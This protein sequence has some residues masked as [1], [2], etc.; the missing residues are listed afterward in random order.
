MLAVPALSMLQ[1]FLQSSV[2]STFEPSTRL[3]TIQVVPEKNVFPRILHYVWPN[4][5]FSFG[6][7]DP[8]GIEQRRTLALVEIIRDSNPEWEVKIW[9]DDDCYSLMKKHFP[10]FYPYWTALTPR[11]KMWDAVRPAILH[12]HGGIY[13][14]HDIDCDEGVHFTNWLSPQT[15]LLLREPSIGKRRKLGNHF[16]GSSPGHSIWKLYMDNIVK[17][18]PWNYPV[19][20]HTGPEQLYATFQEYIIGITL[21]QRS[22]LRLLGLHELDM[23]GECETAAA[24][25]GYCAQ[26]RCSHMHTV[27]PA[28][29]A[30]EDD[31]YEKQVNEFRQGLARISYATSA[32]ACK[33]LERSI[34][35]TS[36]LDSKQDNVPVLFVNIPETGGATIE[37]L[38]KSVEPCHASA[39]ELRA[40]D[41]GQY[42]G[43]LT[44]AALRNPIER[45]VLMYKYA[46]TKGNESKEDPEKFDW[47]LG[48]DFA[49]F[50]EA[51]PAR[52]ELNFAPQKHF[53]T[54][55]DSSSL[56][57][58][59][60]ICTE[61]LGAGWRTLQT[62]VPGLMK[63]KS[64][65]SES[66]DLSQVEEKT[67][68]CLR[69]IY[70]DDFLLWEEYCGSTIKE[71]E[72]SSQSSKEM[73]AVTKLAN[74]TDDQ[75][76]SLL[77]CGDEG[78]PCAYFYPALF[79][80][81]PS[82]LGYMQNVTAKRQ[83]YG[84]PYRTFHANWVRFTH[85]QQ[86]YTYIHTRKA[87]GTTMKFVGEALT[88]NGYAHARNNR[89]GTTLKFSGQA[90][91]S[92]GTRFTADTQFTNRVKRRYEA[93]G[94]TQF[95][96]ETKNMVNS[97]TLFTFVRDPLSR[98][99]SAMGQVASKKK[100]QV[101]LQERG[102]FTG[103]AVND[104]KCVLERMKNGDPVNEH[105][106]QASIEMYQMS[107]S[108]H[109]VRVAVMSLKHLNSFNKAVLKMN[110]IRANTA[111]SRSRKKQAYSTNLL[112]H[113]MIRDICI[114]YEMDVIMMRSL[115]LAVP[116]CDEFVTDRRRPPR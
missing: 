40:C 37:R 34:N 56:L 101:S 46:H 17:D 96:D 15:S 45:A 47:A 11:L 43:S 79:Y 102:C 64:S 69:E 98:F 107:F 90:L 44:F 86:D 76:K 67:E 97:T 10:E 77:D 95:I 28:E 12:V 38:L 114:V 22:Q 13:L 89:G 20:R 59:E 49:A 41:A 83:L 71:Q 84:S 106:M 74:G 111:D 52:R 112:D 60:I 61:D 104:M 82:G 115:G 62:F 2:L 87:G 100:Q 30:G 31:N 9:T 78:S 94:E 1:W 54:L 27:S 93:I 7:E 39:A 48:M 4:K 5:N 24:Y 53:L 42:D 16:M 65:P 6:D 68:Q 109:H 51:L 57:V 92:N 35:A 110:P 3:S 63:F 55:P 66:F 108:L 75:D 18:I 73:T 116:G 19:D 88:S 72:R 103:I 8:Q 81:S 33:H 105:F 21:E 91:T 36:H 80:D 99:C 29:L 50:V 113:E 25:D 70:H 85:E 26:P 14:D 58:D 32:C 23:D